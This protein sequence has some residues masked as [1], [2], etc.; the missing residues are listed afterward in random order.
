MP[1]RASELAIG[2]FV[3]ARINQGMITNIDAADIPTAAMQRVLNARV[4]FDK[5]LRRSGHVLFRSQLT[6]ASTVVTK[7]DSS[8]VL[9]VATLKD[10]QGNAYTFRF[11]PAA[12]HVLDTG[13][14]TDVPAVATAISG[15]AH[16][17]FRTVVINNQ[18]VFSN[19]GVDYVQVLDPVTPDYDRLGNAPKY[20]Y[21]TGFA[22]R[23]IG[24]NRTDGGSYAVELGWSANGLITEW[25]GA[26][27]VSAGATP[28]TESPSDFADHITGV[29][30]LTNALV[31]PR[32][33]SIWLATRNPVATQPFNFYNAVPG[34]GCN[35]P[36][37][38]APFER[39]LC[40]F[41]PRTGTVW[42]YEIGSTPES[43]GR[44]VDNELVKNIDDPAHVFGSYNPVENE[45]I[46]FVPVVGT[47]I[48]KA[49]TFNFR[50][51]SWSYDEIADICCADDPDVSAGYVAIDDLVGT[52]DQQTVTIDELSPTNAVQP[53]RILGRTDGEILQESLAVSD[54]AGVDYVT[55]IESKIFQQDEEDI[56]VAEVRVE[57]IADEECELS[58]YI[59]KND[60]TYQLLRTSTIDVL[61]RTVLF[62]FKKQFRA[63]QF[64]F[65][66]T[67]T[68]GKFS[69]VKYEV[70]AF[71]SGES[72]R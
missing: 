59:N 12:V 27:D 25:D 18:F 5:T 69:L 63:R 37:S 53:C 26:T 61:G 71:M 70:H 3:E 67:G 8:R 31:I 10:N 4:R 46:V 39:G 2:K 7:P 19:N 33:R 38:A 57:L 30:G 43:I 49:W 20:R 23:V 64:S 6:D 9:K 14:W 29:F 58:L 22:N 56:V 52:I 24:A 66:L 44:P 15:G 21:V 54:D 17:R 62:K 72:K 16:D 68:G 28:L 51:K 13:V 35:A 50:T 40:W 60:T 11:S 48:V 1:P 65:K 32:E 42:V 47:N 45:Y 36:Y 55:E 41:D 34:I